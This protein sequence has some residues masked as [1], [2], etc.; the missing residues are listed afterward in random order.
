MATPALHTDW[1]KI[2]K[3]LDMIVD[4]GGRFVGCLGISS[5]L[6]SAKEVHRTEKECETD[7]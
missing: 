7:L 4:A 2:L 3:Q 1:R 5:I 6:F